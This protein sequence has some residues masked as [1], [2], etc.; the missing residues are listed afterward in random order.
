MHG[1]ITRYKVFFHQGEDLTIKTRV[2]KGT[3]WLDETGLQV[4]GSETISLP[5]PDIIRADLFRLH[6]LGRVIKVDHRKGRLYL[7]V[8]RL[9]IGQFAF[10][11]FFKTG[12]L[13][14]K[15]RALAPAKQS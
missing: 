2:K 1:E 10:I 15:I 8:I 6:G 5:G 7:S 13:H 12:S 14:E 3:A 11:H 4:E 9:M